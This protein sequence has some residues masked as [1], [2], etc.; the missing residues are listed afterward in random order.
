MH[1]PWDLLLV[2]K[3][4]HA[5]KNNGFNEANVKLGTGHDNFYL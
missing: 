4:L 5:K 1:I 2:N 3:Q